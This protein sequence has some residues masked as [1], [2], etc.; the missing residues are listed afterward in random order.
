MSDHRDSEYC[1]GAVL[2]QVED[3]DVEDRIDVLRRAFAAA[4]DHPRPENPPADEPLVAAMKTAMV[5]NRTALFKAIERR[6]DPM[7]AEVQT[8]FHL[9]GDVAPWEYDQVE[10]AIQAFCQAM[11]DWMAFGLGDE[12]GAEVASA[13][14]VSH[15]YAVPDASVPGGYRAL[16]VDECE[17]V[18]LDPTGRDQ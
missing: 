9:T 14:G 12:V 17:A 10:G 16:S 18:G 3:L 11:T 6:I 13:A 5:E 7:L 2:A 8:E 15:V 4:T 1:L